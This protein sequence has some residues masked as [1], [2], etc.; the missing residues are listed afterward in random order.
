MNLPKGSNVMPLALYS[1]HL[2]GAVSL[3][4]QIMM[5]PSVAHDAKWMLSG[6]QARSLTATRTHD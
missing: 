6:H 5:S 4:L 2:M 3:M 1:M